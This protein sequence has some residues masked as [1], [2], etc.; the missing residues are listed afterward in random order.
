MKTQELEGIFRQTRKYRLLSRKQG[1]PEMNECQANEFP[2]S[3]LEKLRLPYRD[4]MLLIPKK[5]FRG[6]PRK[7][8]FGRDEFFQRIF[9]KKV[10][11]GLL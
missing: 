5:P 1:L 7:G 6:K 8:L 10:R 2:G 11:I 3:P 4:R 9:L